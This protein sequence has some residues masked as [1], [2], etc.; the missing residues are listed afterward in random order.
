[1]YK[2]ALASICITG[3]LIANP[4]FASNFFQKL[5]PKHPTKT[6]GTVLKGN[7]ALKTKDGVHNFADFSGTWVGTCTDVDGTEILTI[8]NSEF[9][10][11]VGGKL[12]QIGSLNTD[13]SSNEEYTYFSHML[14]EWNEDHSK[15]L[16]NAS[17][18]NYI[19]SQSIK[20]KG[21]GY[22]NASI[23]LNNDQLIMDYSYNSADMNDNAVCTY[24]KQ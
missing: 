8:E 5:M 19:H 16:I 17:I 20:V 10:L 6:E 14:L 12:Y 15:L 13:S 2:M 22:G 1:M 9:H 7:S 3:S 18:V 11:T 21:F 23:S 24:N 4:V